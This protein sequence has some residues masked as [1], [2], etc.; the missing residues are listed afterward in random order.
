MEDKKDRILRAA[1]V[2]FARF[3]IRKTTMD[4][5][6]RDAR[7]GKSTLYYYFKSKEAVFEAVIRKDS[8]LYQSR[9][10]DA[11]DRAGSSREKLRN[12]MRARMKHLRELKN[13]YSTMTDEYLEN[14]DFVEKARRDFDTYENRALASLLKEGRERGDFTMADV[15]ATTRNFAIVL[16]GLEYFL[17]I[18]NRGKDIGKVCDQMLTTLFEGIAKR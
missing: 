3:G 11:V 12:Y 15:E 5:I 9:L 7:M 2:L 16:K 18:R 10:S 14:F 1:E 8:R 4:E 13:Y 6:A 17:L